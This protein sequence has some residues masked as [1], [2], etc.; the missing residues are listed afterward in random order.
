VGVCL[1][2]YIVPTGNGTRS[3]DGDRPPVAHPLFA[4]ITSL[5]LTMSVVGTFVGLKRIRSS[6]NRMYGRSERL[7]GAALLAI[8]LQT[9]QGSSLYAALVPGDCWHHSSPVDSSQ[10]AEV[11]ENYPPWHR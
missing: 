6:R 10:A 11:G 5:T 8:G 7:S 9:L 1:I 2:Q 3:G 4:P